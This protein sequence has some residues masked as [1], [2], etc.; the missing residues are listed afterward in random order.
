MEFKLTPAAKCDVTEIS[1]YYAEISAE[2]AE[3]FISELQTTLQDLCFEPSIG[4]RR[5]AHLLPD[6][7]L[8]TWHL[9]HFPFLLLYRIDG[10]EIEVLR[11]LHERRDL[12]ANLI[13]REFE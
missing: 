6:Q 1:D 13:S 5:Y 11:V 4:S 9:D 3:R 2:L 8:R 12:A 7:S 10:L